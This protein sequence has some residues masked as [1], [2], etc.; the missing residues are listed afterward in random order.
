MKKNVASGESG[1]RCPYLSATFLKLFDNYADQNF[2]DIKTKTEYW[3]NVCLLCNYTKTDFLSLT[4]PLVQD[5]FSSIAGSVTLGTRKHRLRVY[6]ALARYADEHALLYKI[7]SS[8]ASVFQ[9]VGLEEL[10]MEYKLENL[11]SL[12]DVDRVLAYFKETGDM[13]M[14]ISIGLAL[15]C[16]QTT[17]EIISLEK[18]MIF[19]DLAGNYGIRI[20]IS[21][22][23]DRFVK[24][25]KDLAQIIVCYLNS[26]TDES[27][28]LLLNAYKRQLGAYTLQHRL[29]EACKE[30]GGPMFTM[31]KL[32]VLGIVYMIKGGAPLDKVAEHINVKKK[33]WFFRYN[34]VVKELDNSAVEYAHL[35]IVW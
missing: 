2:K 26:R 10:N 18:G 4:L 9:L 25:P 3:E 29:R 17:D 13:V 1:V 14:F 28:Y 11:P 31:N 19:Q 20:A 6:V 27:P 5:Y 24:I 15:F 22:L 33:D 16:S 32:R 8:L 23:N 35:R 7:G 34:R 30:C 12:Q 21:N